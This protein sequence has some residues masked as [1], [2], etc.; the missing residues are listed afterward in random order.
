MCRHKDRKEQ[1]YSALRWQVGTRAKSAPQHDE[2]LWFTFLFKDV[3][4]C[5]PSSQSGL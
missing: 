4:D 5:G 1:E 3:F 2:W